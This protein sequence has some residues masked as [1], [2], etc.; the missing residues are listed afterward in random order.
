VSGT[1]GAELSDSGECSYPPRPPRLLGQMG[2]HRL[3]RHLSHPHPHPLTLTTSSS[4]L[5]GTSARVLT[6]PQEAGSF[7]SNDGGSGSVSVDMGDDDD[8]E[9]DTNGQDDWGGKALGLAGECYRDL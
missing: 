1:L 7:S 8:D 5:L 6:L 2:P 4:T 3:K 9:D